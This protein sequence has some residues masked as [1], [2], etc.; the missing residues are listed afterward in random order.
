MPDVGMSEDLLLRV[1]VPAGFGCGSTDV[2]RFASSS[3]FSGVGTG[4]SGGGWLEIGLL[5]PQA[6]NPVRARHTTITKQPRSFERFAGHASDKRF[7]RFRSSALSNREPRFSLPAIRPPPSVSRILL[8][9]T[10]PSAFPSLAL[11][12]PKQTA[13]RAPA[14]RPPAFQNPRNC[15]CFAASKP[16]RRCASRT[17]RTCPSPHLTLF[18]ASPERGTRFEYYRNA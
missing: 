14:S 7:T 1:G 4:C 13:S 12:L 15:Q 17:L 5:A 3:F 11:H 6:A 9:E 18:S 16:P 10:A 8:A 2:D